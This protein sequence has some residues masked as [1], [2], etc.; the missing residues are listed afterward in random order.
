[1]TKP[2]EFWTVLRDP[3]NEV[4]CSALVYFHQPVHGAIKHLVVHSR[5]VLPGDELALAYAR[6]EK[7][8]LALNVVRGGGVPYG[9]CATVE[10]RMLAMCDVSKTALKADEEMAGEK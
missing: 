10:E 7:L 4:A 6:I 8:R 2:K 3:V 5:E 9:V 1:M